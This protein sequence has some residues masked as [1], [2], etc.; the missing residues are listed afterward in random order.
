MGN[1]LLCC[2]ND[3]TY[4]PVLESPAAYVV[5]RRKRAIIEMVN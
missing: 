5:E 1:S 2:S 4:D 3:W